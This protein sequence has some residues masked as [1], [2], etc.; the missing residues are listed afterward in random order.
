MARGGAGMAADA[1]A[2][3]VEP[4]ST[5]VAVDVTMTFELR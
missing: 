3:P 2:V 1:A 4:G 5:T